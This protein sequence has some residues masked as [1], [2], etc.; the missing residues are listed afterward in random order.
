MLQQKNELG[1]GVVLLGVDRK[2]QVGELLAPGLIDHRTG[3]HIQG[4][5]VELVVG[6]LVKDDFEQ[7]P[8]QVVHPVL[9]MIG[10]LE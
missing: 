6:G 7:F 10:E 2:D 1:G 4:R 8:A 5:P 3:I 9:T